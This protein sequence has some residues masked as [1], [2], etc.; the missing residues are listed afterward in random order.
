MEVSSIRNYITAVV[1][2]LPTSWLQLTTH[3]LDIYDEQ[4]AKT[5]FLDQFDSLY[6]NNTT[7]RAALD[8]LPT[9]Y[10][11][12]RLGHPLSCVLEWAIAKMHQLQPANVISFSSQTIPILAILRKNLL[13]HKNTQI[14]YTDALPS[15]FD[16]EVL[17]T[18]YGYTFELKKVKNVDEIAEFNGSTIFISQHDAIAELNLD[19]MIDFY[20]NLYAD[21]GSI[22]LVNGLYFRN[23]ACS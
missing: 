10:D 20:I 3:R 1:A 18:I 15:F 19:P 9:A 11:Y 6:K 12:I 23:S 13:D 14:L 7:T 17:R 16:T 5:Q 22:I 2:Q 21:L 8:K 4:L